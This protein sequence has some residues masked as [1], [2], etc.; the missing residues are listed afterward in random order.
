MKYVVRDDRCAVAVVRIEEA[1]IGVV[2][3][4]LRFDIAAPIVSPP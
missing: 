4:V 3:L 1:K 2:W